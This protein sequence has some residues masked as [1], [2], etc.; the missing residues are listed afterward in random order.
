MIRKPT[1]AQRGWPNPPF[2]G[3]PSAVGIERVALSRSR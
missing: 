3:E 2:D 1:E